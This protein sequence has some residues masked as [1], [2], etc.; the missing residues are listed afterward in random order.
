VIYLDLGL[1]GD[2]RLPVSRWG[3]S[4]LED[5]K[6]ILRHGVGGPVPVVCDKLDRQ[7]LVGVV[8]KTY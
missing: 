5:A 1:V 2:R 7:R 4:D 8:A 6:L 3:D